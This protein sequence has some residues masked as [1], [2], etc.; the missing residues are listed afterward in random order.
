M[1]DH[2][3]S[4]VTAWVVAVTAIV[5][6]GAG[7]FGS[8]YPWAYVPL[9]GAAALVG[10][11]GIAWGRS[12]MAWPIGAGLIAIIIAGLLQL[13]PLP[14]DLLRRLSP[15]TI[16]LLQQRDVV[17]SYRLESSYPLSIAPQRTE[18]ALQLLT[19][20]SLL[21]VGSARMLTRDGAR[22]LVAGIA[23][24][25]ALLALIGIVHRATSSGLIYGFWRPEGQG[26]GFAPFVNRN[27]FAG[28]MLMA[29][30]LTAG[31]FASSVS[32]GMRDTETGF[33]N[34][35]L[36]FS[37]PDG[38]GSLLLGFA[39]IAMS[40][41]VMLTTSRSGVLAMAGA[42]CV[43]GVVMGRRQRRVTR[44][45]AVLAGVLGPLL[46]VAAW[47]GLDQIATRLG[48]DDL[49]LLS[50][51]SMIWADTIRIVRDF[52]LFG[53]GLNT[54]GVSTLFYQTV[55]P[56]RHVNEAHNDYLQIAAEGGLLVGIPVL[57]CIV[58][59]CQ[60]LRRRFLQDAGSIWWIRTGAVIGLLAI[61]AQSVVEFSLQLPGNAVLF[62][63]LCGIALHD[64]RATTKSR[65]QA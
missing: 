38:G 23:T 64:G 10:L 44:Q 5:A 65:R 34:R 29:M 52:P 1:S 51:R 43:G 7:A 18:L 33:K 58:V 31:L 26:N 16:E 28:W 42:L 9:A 45:V 55:L 47:V 41:A 49:D 57:C 30:P 56:D 25:G 13:A 6:W 27:H 54:Y 12:A 22:H 46:I 63:V 19:A 3:S 8:P 50:T 35:L 36:W 11:I 60:A 2:A 59:F 32:R 39:L 61:A 20:F 62:C 37:T 4:R 21:V 14:L 40:M 24:V 15:H 53:T 48:G 17:M